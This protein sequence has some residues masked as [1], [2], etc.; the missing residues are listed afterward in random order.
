MTTTSAPPRSLSF[1]RLITTNIS[2]RLLIDIGAQMFNPFLPI[3]AA[4]MGVDVV[5]MGRLVALRGTMG[6][7]STG[8]GTIADRIG[9][10][11]VMAFALLTGAIGMAVLGSS[12]SL[13]QLIIGMSLIGIS[14]AGFVPT[15]QAYLSSLLPYHQLARGM[16]M[17]EY[18]WA[19]TGIVGLSL[20]GQLIAATSWRVPFYILSVGMLIAYFVIRAMPTS[21]AQ[22]YT[23]APPTNEAAHQHATHSPTLIQR[24]GNFFHIESNALST[25]S[26]LIATA[27]LFFGAMQIMVVHGIWFADQF[28]FG[29]SE[30]GYVALLFGCFDLVASVMVSIFTDRF[31]MRRSVIVGNIG[32]LIGYLLIPWFNVAMIPAVVSLAITRC[33]FEFAVVANL[34]LLSGQSPTQR[35]KV[36]TL[37]STLV[38]S[39]GTIA[40][41]SAPMLYTNIG[42]TGIAII[43]VTC[44]MLSLLLLFTTVRE[45]KAPI[46][47]E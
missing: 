22:T 3:F 20:M 35:G 43:S 26:N 21:P 5:T 2:A 39:C 31:G 42:I 6:L 10:Q 13:L 36:M 14:L 25:Y 17:L 18:S 16:G 15:Q 12:N 40:A 30:L 33:F 29:P 28:N 34:P 41:F 32:A 23:P 38:L 47:T 1:A 27:L 44:T 7:F 24:V 4:G 11:R 46:I 19:L 45:R 8:I 9:Y 37:N